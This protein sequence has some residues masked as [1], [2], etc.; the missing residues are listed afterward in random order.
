MNTRPGAIYHHAEMIFHNGVAGKKYMV[1]VNTPGTK[2]HFVFVKT[3]SQ[4]KNKRTS[5]NCL[6]KE[7]CYFINENQDFFKKDTWVQLHERYIFPPG[8]IKNDNNITFKGCLDKNLAESIVK[9][10]LEIQKNDLSQVEMDL[11]CPPLN[12]A[13]LKL[14]EKFNTEKKND[15]HRHALI[16]GMV[17]VP[18]TAAKAR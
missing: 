7:A 15:C 17:A 3:T 11:I 8:D 9:C 2:E 4:R 1:L 5:P 10:L 16:W 18:E 13:L 12:Q 6:D 14:Q